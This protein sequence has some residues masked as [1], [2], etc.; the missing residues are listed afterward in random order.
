VAYVT[1]E[2]AVRTLGVHENTLRRWAK[3]GL[4]KHYRVK[5]TGHRYY[6]VEDLLER[7]QAKLARKR[8]LLT[9]QQ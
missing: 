9:G 8:A 1:T 2:Q 3:Q 4:I 5:E 6:D 7:E